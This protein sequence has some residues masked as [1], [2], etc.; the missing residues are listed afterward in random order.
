MCRAL[1][2]VLVGALL[3]LPL[4]AAEP[5]SS[6]P[7][8]SSAAP[9]ALELSPMSTAQVKSCPINDPECQPCIPIYSD[10]TR[11][12]NSIAFV[13]QKP[14]QVCV[15]V[16]SYTDTCYDVACDRAN[17]RIT[18]GTFRV[19]SEPYEYPVG[20]CPAADINFCTTMTVE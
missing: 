7:D 18:N 4:A 15:Y 9:F 16:C 1:R 19:R 14:N 17:P 12:Y 6:S 3:A 20:G 2:F 8:S 5:M 10:C 13:Q 11:A